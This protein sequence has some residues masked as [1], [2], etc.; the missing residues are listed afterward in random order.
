[1]EGQ[2]T[3]V[4]SEYLARRMGQ[5][6]ESTP[7]LAE[8]MS[9]S[10]EAAAGQYPVFETAPLY[11][12]K[13]LVFPY[14]Q[15]LLFHQK[16]LERNGK[17]AFALVFRR[18]PVS[19]SQILHPEKYFASEEPSTPALPRFAARGYK[20]LAEGTFGEL[21]HAILLE[22]YIGKAEAAAM[23]PHWRGGTYRLWED[24]SRRRQVLAYASE[25][26]SAEA[27]ARFFGLYREVLRKK[28][29]KTE[30]A[31]ETEGR[32]TGMGDD[33]YFTLERRDRLVTCLEGLEAPP[34]PA[35]H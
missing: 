7:S 20:E 22:Q 1:M 25:W 5:S 12:R 13:T 35:L 21:D 4:M 34:A 14:T 9:R 17:D 31:E 19:T 16:V 3:W 2:A 33:G 10:G 8:T 29:K 24:R 6:L 15:G 18:P 26:E 28:W 30:V 11:M 23:V 32:V 27:A